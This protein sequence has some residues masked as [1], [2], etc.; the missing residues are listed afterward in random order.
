MRRRRATTQPEPRLDVEWPCTPLKLA[1]VASSG[2]RPS[3]RVHVAMRKDT[4]CGAC[5]PDKFMTGVAPPGPVPV[6]KFAVRHADR[7]SGNHGTGAD[8]PRRAASNLA[9]RLHPPV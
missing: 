1:A 3:V 4:R 6:V 9:R 2:P 8:D 5:P 7:V